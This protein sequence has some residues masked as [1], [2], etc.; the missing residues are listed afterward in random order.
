MAHVLPPSDEM[1]NL[2]A[3][4]RADGKTWEAISKQI[5]REPRTLRRWRIKYRDRWDPIQVRAERHVATEGECESVLVLR[6]LL[7]SKDEKTRWHA[8]KS[9]I[10]LRLELGKLDLRRSLASPDAKLSPEIAYLTQLQGCSDAELSTML[11]D[12]E[13][14]SPAELPALPADPVVGPE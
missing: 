1:L 11:Q 12:L 8:A 13:R 5:N 14:R 7:R 3:E 9:L 10:A 6:V 2:V 4:L